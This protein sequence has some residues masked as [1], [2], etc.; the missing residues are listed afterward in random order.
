MNY[1]QVR[2]TFHDDVQFVMDGMGE[3]Q[4]LCGCHQSLLLGQPVQPPQCVFDVLPP[5]KLLEEFF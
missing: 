1:Q 3:I 5:H 4:D 2:Y